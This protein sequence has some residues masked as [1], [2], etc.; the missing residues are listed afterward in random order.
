MLP[1]RK[2]ICLVLVCFLIMGMA[3]LPVSASAE[4]AME[5]EAVPA[6]QN[7]QQEAS[8]QTDNP[9]PHYFQTD[10]PDVRF[11]TGTVATNGCSVTSLAMVASYMTGHQYMPDELARYFGGRAENNVA[12]L[13]MGS[14]ALQLPYWRAENWH[15]TYNALKAGKIAIVLV[16][17]RVPFTQSQHF[18]V[19]KG[20][21]E[22]GKIQVYDTNRSNY[23]KSE[24]KQ[25]FA[26]G[27]DPSLILYGYSGGWIY[28]VEA[29]PEDPFI[30][31]EPLPDHSYSRYPEV[32]LTLA[33][34]DLLARVVWAEARGE[35]EDGQQAVAE[36]VL[37]RMV[38][39]RF[40]HTLRDVIYGEGQFR[41]VPYL[42]DAEPSQAQ[43]EAIER[44]LYGPNILPMDVYYFATTPT[45]PRVWGQIGGHVFCYA[46]E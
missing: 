21:N 40:P 9:F 27:F 29:M 5:S 42:E 31:Y 23:E 10:Y 8:N 28:D 34:E 36:V 24:L 25:G 37:N 7:S 16:D 3:P 2:R 15:E 1:F 13:E 4:A 44:A 14:D 12:R 11:G 22:A 19:L 18:L 41:S 30:Y 35:C 38:S 32:E 45:N 33:Q 17:K 46:E 43:Y 39:D 20:I 6:E 26:E